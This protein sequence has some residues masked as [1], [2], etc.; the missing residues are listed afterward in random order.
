MS[1]LFDDLP[2]FGRT[3][4]PNKHLKPTFRTFP[5]CGWPQLLSHGLLHVIPA[6]GGWFLTK[7]RGQHPRYKLTPG[8]LTQRVDLRIT[9]VF[10]REFHM[11]NFRLN[12]QTCIFFSWLQHIDILR[13]GVFAAFPMKITA[14]EVEDKKTE[15]QH[16]SKHNKSYCMK[17]YVQHL[18]EHLFSKLFPRF[19]FG[20]S[21]F[22]LNETFIFF[23]L[24]SHPP[25]AVLCL[26]EGPSCIIQLWPGRE[27]Y[28]KMENLTYSFWGSHKL[29]GIVQ[30]SHMNY[31]VST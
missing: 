11:D 17:L 31:V 15:S 13:L 26:L 19:W 22:L 18:Q 27:K 29:L 23:F 24:T 4:K 8:G 3:C 20:S 6:I 10:N 1:S 30:M 7:K 28:G 5:H 2:L 21:L 14:A 9:Q 12:Q 16:N 25:W